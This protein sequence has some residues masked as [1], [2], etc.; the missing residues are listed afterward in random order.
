MITSDHEDFEPQGPQRL[1]RLL[2]VRF[3]SIRDGDETNPAPVHR[4]V[5]GG[6]AVTGA[7][8]GGFP[9]T[10]KRYARLLHVLDIAHQHR[11]RPDRGTDTMP[12]HGLK[13]LT[14]F[15]R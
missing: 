11:L 8:L 13:I 3:Q 5:H 2:G 1:D 4:H 14:L 9:E 10:A 6:F 12:R 7:R 15:Q